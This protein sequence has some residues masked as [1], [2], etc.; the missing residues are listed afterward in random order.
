MRY[1]TT[2][3]SV[4]K[5]EKSVKWFNRKAEKNG[6]KTATVTFGE[7]YKKEVPVY[8]VDEL[9]NIQTKVDTIIVDVVDFDLIVPDYKIGDYTLIGII[10]HEEDGNNRV[11]EMSDRIVPTKYRH[12]S[13]VCEHCMRNVR[14]NKTA[15][16]ANADT[17][18]QVGIS[19]LK[20]YTGIDEAFIAKFRTDIASIIESDECNIGY[21]SGET[22]SRKYV[23]TLYYLSACVHEIRKNGYIKGN[24][25]TSTKNVADREMKFD[26]SDKEIA[27]NVI[28]YFSAMD[29]E[30]ISTF[31]NNIR[32]AVKDEFCRICDGF[33]AY[34]Y[35][36]WKKHIEEESN[37]NNTVE[38]NFY[39]N[40]GEKI[41]N[42]EVTGSM[43]A[44]YE[45]QYGVTR[46]Y[47]F[48]DNNGHTFIWKTSNSIEYNTRNVTFGCT[49][50]GTIKEH[51][52]YNN[53]K[54]TVI[55]RA[56]VVVC[57][58]DK[59]VEEELPFGTFDIDTVMS[60]FFAD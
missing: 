25:Y 54:Q 50:S 22:P 18:K 52:T 33:V 31:E 53:E 60:A 28:S 15:I 3:G 26:D 44:S 48:T 36:A 6:M 24:E 38:N 17:Y 46:I 27:Q 2:I 19:C 29:S 14:R 43:V 49:I 10:D 13:C 47:K 37:N 20:E 9:T 1:T 11:Y 4:A 45:T 34:A 7:P 5:I 12:G 8:V 57:D 40:V 56:K 58:A 16:I 23:C 41:K 39:G 42:I 21:R 30:S 51:N 55:T 32:V 59:P 35:V